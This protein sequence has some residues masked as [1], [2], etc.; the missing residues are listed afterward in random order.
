M[1]YDGWVDDCKVRIFDWIDGRN[2]YMNMQYFAPG[3][4]LEGKP[5]REISVLIPKKDEPMLQK[6]LHSVVHHFMEGKA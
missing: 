2:I 4:S 1:T 3:I 6:Y 5:A